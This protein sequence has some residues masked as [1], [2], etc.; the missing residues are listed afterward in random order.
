MEI[1][2]KKNKNY[3]L[4]SGEYKNPFWEYNIDYNIFVLNIKLDL[5]KYCKNYL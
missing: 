3:E 1:L 4:F 5:N 2:K